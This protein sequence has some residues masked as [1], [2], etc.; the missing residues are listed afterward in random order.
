MDTGD[1]YFNAGNKPTIKTPLVAK[2]R[3]E[4]RRGLVA[5]LLIRETTAENIQVIDTST[6]M[7]HKVLI[8]KLYRRHYWYRGKHYTDVMH[9]PESESGRLTQMYD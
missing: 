8:V 2:N 9:Y 1:V 5:Q 3:A 7:T 6:Y 4:A